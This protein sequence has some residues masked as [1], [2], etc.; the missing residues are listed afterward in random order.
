MRDWAAMCW[1]IIE[2]FRHVEIR[3]YFNMSNRCACNNSCGVVNALVECKRRN[4]WILDLL[5]L[6][7]LLISIFSKPHCLDTTALSWFIWTWHH[8]CI[9]RFVVQHRCEFHARTFEFN[10]L[11][12]PGISRINIDLSIFTTTE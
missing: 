7:Y 9:L 12:F 8:Q 11:L 6:T 1:D 3:I 5:S 4:I 10:I 2:G